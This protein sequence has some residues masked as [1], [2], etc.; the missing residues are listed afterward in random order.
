MVKLR[1]GDYVITD[2][3]RTRIR[4]GDWE[5]FVLENAAED[6]RNTTVLIPKDPN[7]AA[8]AATDLLVRSLCEKGIYAQSVRASTSKLDRF[9]PFSALAQNGSVKIVRGCATDLENKIYG[10]NEFFYKELEAFTG[11][12]KKT[13]VG[14]DDLCDAVSDATHKLTS[15]V[16]I[17]NFLSGIKS[18]QSGLRDTNPLAFAR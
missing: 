7:P 18:M 9:R 10:S 2:I 6:D 12:R 14:H 11:V 3:K 5:N 15:K 17:G 8:A 13:E 1:S 4:F 16:N